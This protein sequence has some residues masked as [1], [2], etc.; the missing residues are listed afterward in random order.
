MSIC[1]TR[2]T[3]ENFIINRTP[4]LREHGLAVASYLVKLI[5]VPVGDRTPFDY[6]S[7]ALTFAEICR[8]TRIRDFSNPWNHHPSRSRRNPRRWLRELVN[9]PYSVRFRSAAMFTC[10]EFGSDHKHWD[11]YLSKIML[12]KVWK[13]RSLLGQNLPL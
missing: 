3:H 11:G 8:P 10:S 1:D 4:P 13:N 7:P 9:P 12:I 6:N 2:N 5:K